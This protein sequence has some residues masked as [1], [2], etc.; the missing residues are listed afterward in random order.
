MSARSHLRW[1]C[2]RACRRFGLCVSGAVL[3]VSLD[4]VPAWIAPL[5]ARRRSRCSNGC[6]DRVHGRAVRTDRVFAIGHAVGGFRRIY[7][8]LRRNVR[9]YAARRVFGAGHRYAPSVRLCSALAVVAAAWFAC[10]AAWPARHAP[11]PAMR[12]AACKA[13]SPNRSSGERIPFRTART[14]CIADLKGHAAASALVVWPETVIP[15]DLNDTAVNWNPAG[16]APAQR[17]AVQNYL[18]KTLR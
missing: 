2:S 10:F 12:V 16:A 18:M 7:R 15:T 4:L 14:L 8:L 11:A 1:S 13:T 5:P 17:D 3:R 9:R 6:V